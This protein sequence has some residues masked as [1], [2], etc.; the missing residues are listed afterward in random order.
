MPENFTFH[1]RQLLYNVE[2][3]SL[4]ASGKFTSGL[5]LDIQNALDGLGRNA[6]WHWKAEDM[7]SI[8]FARLHTRCSSFLHSELALRFPTLRHVNG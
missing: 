5:T 1:S 4:S 8:S 6:Q 7:R 2:S 3:P